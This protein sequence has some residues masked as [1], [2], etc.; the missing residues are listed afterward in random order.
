MNAYFCAWFIIL[1]LL[2]AVW[3][4]VLQNLAVHLLTWICFIFFCCAWAMEPELLLPL[5]WASSCRLVS[6]WLPWVPDEPLVSEAAVFLLPHCTAGCGEGLGSPHEGTHWGLETASFCR[7]VAH[8]KKH[9]NVVSSALRG[10]SEERC[11]RSL[12]QL[13]HI[14]CPWGQRAFLLTV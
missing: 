11:F 2:R 13:F 12:T 7:C 3:L 1:A 8:Y 5:S 14:R 6:F 4:R 9:L 10:S